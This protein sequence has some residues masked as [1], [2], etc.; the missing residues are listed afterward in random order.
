MYPNIKRLSGVSQ[1]EKEVIIIKGTR[2]IGNADYLTC[3]KTGSLINAICVFSLAYNLYIM[4]P[5]IMLYKYGFYDNCRISR[6][7]TG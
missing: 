7:L 2:K 3:L 5:Y 4:S 6:A 1:K